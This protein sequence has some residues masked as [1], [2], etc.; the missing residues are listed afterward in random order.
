MATSYIMNGD[1][2]N[3]VSVVDVSELMFN[4]VLLHPTL[5]QLYAEQENATVN[6]KYIP[7]VDGSKTYYMYGGVNQYVTIFIMKLDSNNKLVEYG[8]R[9]YD[10]LV[11]EFTIEIV[12]GIEDP[13]YPEN[14]TVAQ[15]EEV[16]TLVEKFNN[17][18][19]AN[20][21]DVS[22][23][24]LATI[25]VSKM[26]D[27]VPEGF[28]MTMAM[29][30]GSF[31]GAEIITPEIAEGLSDVEITYNEVEGFAEYHFTAQIRM[32]PD[33]DPIEIKRIYKFNGDALVKYYTNLS[34]A[35]FGEVTIAI[36]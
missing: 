19:M 20:L 24:Y 16:E 5:F 32:A 29:D 26:T 21:S 14:P 36:L 31:L 11:R 1:S 3:P 17:A 10:G 28:T 25:D 30:D 33:A 4:G 18:I 2:S 27:D 23:I 13:E 34:I 12:G 6:A 9:R 35:G 15:A 8:L 7:G 22:K